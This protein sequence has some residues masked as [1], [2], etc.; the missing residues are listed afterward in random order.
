MYEAP[1]GRTVTG[2]LQELGERLA[3]AERV[4]MDIPGFRRAAVLVPLL[5]AAD[6]PQLLFT[7]RAASLANH[8]GQIAF[9]G[10]GAEPGET[11]EAAALRET[12][13][14]VGLRVPPEAVLG[15]LSDHP[16][17]AGYVATPVVARIPWPQ[18][19]RLNPIEVAEVFTVPL[20]ELAAITPDSEV[21]QLRDYRRRIFAYPW[22]GRRIWGFTGNVVK[23]LLDVLE[24]RP[25][26]PFDPW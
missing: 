13:E 12:E 18:P 10:G 8:A 6:G 25:G 19:M 24:G 1:L 3:A 2:V 11:L 15:T 20:A 22:N 21:K 26:D 7:V 14:E 16:S 23:N 5:D 4:P 9:P 17:P